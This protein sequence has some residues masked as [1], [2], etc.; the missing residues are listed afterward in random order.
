MCKGI[1]T[2]AYPNKIIAHRITSIMQPCSQFLGP[3]NQGQVPFKA[4]NRQNSNLSLKLGQ[5]KC[6]KSSDQ[7]YNTLCK[8][9][10]T[11]AYPHTPHQINNAAL[12]QFLW[13]RK[14]L[15]IKPA[16]FIGQKSKPTIGIS[17]WIYQS[18]M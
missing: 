6:K 2:C 7:C 12:F 11:C 18:I 13:R 9:I 8:G 15:I 3:K 1:K 14:M 10:K 4:Q 16:W 5:K 17:Q